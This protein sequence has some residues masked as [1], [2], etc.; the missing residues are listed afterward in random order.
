MSKYVYCTYFFLLVNHSLVYPESSDIP[1]FT[2]KDI[3][4]YYFVVHT[5]YV[6]ISLIKK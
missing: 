1:Y 5:S 6:Q 2:A 4:K 3:N